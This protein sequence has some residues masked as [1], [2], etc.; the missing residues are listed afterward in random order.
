[1]QHIR[2]PGP[3]P[4]RRAPVMCTGFPPFVDTDNTSHFAQEYSRESIRA[5]AW[6]G[7]TRDERYTPIFHT[8]HLQLIS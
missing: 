3:L 8:R 7:E 6:M 1:M 4:D 2:S 5:A